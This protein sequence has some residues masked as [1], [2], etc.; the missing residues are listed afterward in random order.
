MSSS[1][2]YHRRASCRRVMF[3]QER[4]L[5]LY[6]RSAIRTT[7]KKTKKTKEK[8]SESTS[9][10]AEAQ[11]QNGYMCE[12]IP[13][14]NEGE[15]S[16]RK[17]CI[18]LFSTYTGARP[19]NIQTR[20]STASS[21]ALRM[22]GEKEKKKRKSGKGRCVVRTILAHSVLLFF[23]FF[24]IISQRGTQHKNRRRVYMHR[25]SALVNGL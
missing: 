14:M 20:K 18:H 4:S 7:A 10:R 23:S 12:M 13:P 17:H 11:Q 16:L 24:P 25:T 9:K 5:S 8:K 22:Q 1:L 21:S 2:G 3:N 6:S 15:S 19:T